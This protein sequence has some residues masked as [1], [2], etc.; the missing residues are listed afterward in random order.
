[1]SAVLTT[2]REAARAIAACVATALK[3]AGAVTP[4][5][6]PTRP[7]AP[8]I[9]ELYLKA[10][11]ELGKMSAEGIG[12]ALQYLREITVKAPDFVLALAWHSGCLVGLGYWGH[13]PIRETYPSAKQ[14][15]LND[16]AIDDSLDRSFR[17]WYRLAARLG[18]AASERD[19][20][21]A[22]ELSPSNSDAHT[23]YAIFLGSVG[24]FSDSIAEGRYALRLDPTLAPREHSAR[25]GVSQR[26][27]VGKGEA[28]QADESFPDSLHAHRARVGGMV[29]RRAAE[30]VAA[31][32]NS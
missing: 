25:L 6:V 1:M 15:A 9:V 19:F 28:G 14:M 17:S 5:G 10:R 26:T 24:R 23:L 2:Q 8:E 11:T 12:K 7:V 29:L 30:A 20:R 31:F 21:R 18:L 13:A 4:V 27:P 22:I 3:P 32:E 16:L